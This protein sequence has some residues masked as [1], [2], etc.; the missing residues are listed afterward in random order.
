MSGASPIKVIDP[1]YGNC[2]N[3]FSLHQQS[4]FGLQS[5][6][7]FG[8]SFCFNIVNRGASFPAPTYYTILEIY[9]NSCVKVSWCSKKN[10]SVMC[11]VSF[12]SVAII[13]TMIYCI[14]NVCCICCIK[15]MSKCG[16]IHTT[17]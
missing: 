11:C 13:L 14:L 5:K 17:N 12:I 10:F 8:I 7:L 15:Y 4:P 9:R 1:E 6:S 2:G 3:S 16:K